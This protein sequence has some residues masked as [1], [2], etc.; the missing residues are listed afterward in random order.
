MNLNE[1]SAFLK[2]TFEKSTKAEMYKMWT[3]SRAQH[4]EM[5]KEEMTS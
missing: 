3:P 5:T 4:F 2:E 1:S